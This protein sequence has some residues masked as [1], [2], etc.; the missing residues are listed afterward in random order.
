MSYHQKKQHFND[1]KA[2]SRFSKALKKIIVLSHFSNTRSNAVKLLVPSNRNKIIITWACIPS[3]SCPRYNMTFKCNM[4]FFFYPTITRM[5]DEKKNLPLYD[6]N[7]QF[8]LSGNQD[9]LRLFH[10]LMVSE[11]IDMLGCIHLNMSSNSNSFFFFPISWHSPSS[12]CLV[13]WFFFYF[14]VKVLLI[15][16][17]PINKVKASNQD[18]AFV[19]GGCGA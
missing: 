17:E 15:G 4:L 16:L 1:F 7:K 10:F 6:K 14:K 3:L 2:C 18:T 11:E 12:F 19:R 5:K 13:S 8:L 9:D